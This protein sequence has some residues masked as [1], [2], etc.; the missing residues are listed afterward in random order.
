MGLFNNLT[1]WL[2]ANLYISNDELQMRKDVAAAQ[3]AE[4]D[5]QFAE[6]KISFLSD[7]SLSADIQDAGSSEQK[8]VDANSGVGGFLKIV[9]WWFW[10]AA[11]IAA[12]WYLG[13]FSYLRGI[14][15][16]KTA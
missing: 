2:A 1:D 4:V 13:G 11:I 15:K 9:P 14:L 8:F 16:K 12:F 5:R 7:L 3:Q 6:G 10:I